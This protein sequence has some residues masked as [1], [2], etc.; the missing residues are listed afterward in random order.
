[1]QPRESPLGVPPSRRTT[2]D[3]ERIDRCTLLPSARDEDGV[4][5]VS[6]PHHPAAGAN[7]AAADQNGLTALR[8]AVWRYLRT[9]GC[10]EALADDLTQDVFVVVLRRERFDARDPAA[11]FAFLR[12]TAR[13]LL[14]KSRRRRVAERD[15]DEADAVWDARCRDGAGEDYVE[16]L[17]HCLET[18]P[19]R[20]RELLAATYG[21]GHGRT[22]AGQRFGLSADG[23][24]S[25]LRRVRALLHACITRRLEEQ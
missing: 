3:H 25:A 13:H 8:P 7:Q 5:L 1:M 9:L 16:A 14:L 11:A 23:V 17:R 6:P 19:A 22:T 12:S 4:T 10:D 2:A 24:K 20:S 15:V 21:D 18:L